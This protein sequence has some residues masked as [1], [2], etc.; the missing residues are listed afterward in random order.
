[1]HKL[2]SETDFQAPR[3]QGQVS[4]NIPI[5]RAPYVTQG[6]VWKRF[7]CECGRVI[8]ITKQQAQ[9]KIASL[10]GL[11]DFFKVECVCGEWQHVFRR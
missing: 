6:D 3:H 5:S 8:V 9:A 7:R 2:Q 1:M 11:H 4:V 10:R